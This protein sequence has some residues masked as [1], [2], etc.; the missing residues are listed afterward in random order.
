MALARLGQL[1]E[2]AEWSVKAAARPNAHAQ[3]LAVAAYC[4]TLADR[5]DEARAHMAAIH[6]TLPRYGID[7]FLAAYKLQPE[8]ALLFRKAA[9]EMG[10]E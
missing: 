2:A 10:T 3:I 1:D 5:L 7:H 9:K 6:Q 8:A 4:L